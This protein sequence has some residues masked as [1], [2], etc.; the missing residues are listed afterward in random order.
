MA[1]TINDKDAGQKIRSLVE[2]M[3]LYNNPQ[4][5]ED[6]KR[7]MKKNVPF[8]MRGYLLA[9]LYVTRNGMMPSIMPPAR[10]HMGV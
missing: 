6:M 3:K 5:L 1:E 9:Y 8:M 7:L 2:E 4:E 10:T